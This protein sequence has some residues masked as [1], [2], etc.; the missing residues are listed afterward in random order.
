MSITKATKTERKARILVVE[1]D[2]EIRAL[3]QRLLAK[4]YTVV[5]AADGRQGLILAKKLNPDLLL[6]DVMLPELDGFDL[7]AAIRSEEGL[8]KVPIMFLTARD[9]PK[10][11]IKGIQAGARHYLTKPF[12]IQDVLQK[13][14]R[15]LQR[16]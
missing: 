4:S 16:G 9:T 10:D 11:T 2:E 12:K 3:L 14:E 13:V 7:A 8:K 15:I 1:D 5:G 6:L